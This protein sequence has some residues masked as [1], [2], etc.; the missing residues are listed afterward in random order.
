MTDFRGWQRM[1]EDWEGNRTRVSSRIASQL[2]T[3]NSS[4]ERPFVISQGERKAVVS[5]QRREG[6]QPGATPRES[7]LAAISALKGRRSPA[8]LQ[9]ANH[10]PRAETQGVALGWLPMA[11]SAPEGVV[12]FEA[13][14]EC[15]SH[16]GGQAFIIKLF[17]IIYLTQKPIFAI[18]SS[19]FSS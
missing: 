11:L 17:A 2:S 13:P 16:N 15:F 4:H 9:G 18:L 1:L 19:C 3:W 10:L 7:W 6:R 8:P 14:I 5:R 12:F